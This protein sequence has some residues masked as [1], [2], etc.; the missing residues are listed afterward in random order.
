MNEIS[1]ASLATLP[2][3]LRLT[4]LRI[5]SLPV[6]WARLDEQVLQQSILAFR[7]LQVLVIG[8]RPYGGIY[9]MSCGGLRLVLATLT[10]LTKL[11]STVSKNHLQSSHHGHLTLIQVRNLF[12]RPLRRHQQG[13]CRQHQRTMDIGRQGKVKVYTRTVFRSR[14]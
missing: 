2:Q 9:E 4:H 7:N 8:S 10:S 3:P 13:Q 14:W 5:G 11:V 1:L 6:V 12:Q